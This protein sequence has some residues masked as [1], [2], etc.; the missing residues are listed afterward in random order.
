MLREKKIN[1]KIDIKAMLVQENKKPKKTMTREK[2]IKQKF[3]PTQLLSFYDF[4][5]VACLA[6]LPANVIEKLLLKM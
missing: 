1:K 2:E 6:S 3:L 5:S 4:L